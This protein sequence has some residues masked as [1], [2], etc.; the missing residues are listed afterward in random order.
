MNPLQQAIQQCDKP[1][2]RMRVYM[3]AINYL[4]NGVDYTHSH[5]VV[6][7]PS[8]PSAYSICSALFKSI[9]NNTK[10][11]DSMIITTDTLF[12]ILP[13]FKELFLETELI[14]GEYFF[15][16]EPQYVVKRIKFLKRCMS[17]LTGVEL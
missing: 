10:L 12:V 3:D 5:F 14:A 13:E 7:N 4:E 1:E 11:S 15:P 8:K 16:L 2:V 6:V 17:V 9:I